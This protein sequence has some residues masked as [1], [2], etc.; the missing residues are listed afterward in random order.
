MFFGSLSP[1]P[2]GS[3][4]GLPVPPAHAGAAAAC[5]GRLGTGE[6]QTRGATPIKHC[7]LPAG[8]SLCRCTAAARCPILQRLHTF[9]GTPAAGRLQAAAGGACRGCRPRSIAAVNAA[10]AEAQAC[11][12]HMLP[13]SACE[14][15]LLPMNAFFYTHT[16]TPSFR[17]NES[18]HVNTSAPPRQQRAAHTSGQVAHS[19]AASKVDPGNPERH[20]QPL[21]V[22]ICRC[23][24]GNSSSI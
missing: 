15:A 23:G 4:G 24:G 7:L 16:H 6:Q 18:P 5:S 20:A 13:V 9:V 3:A 14:W 1:A 12:L 10:A 21:R 17:S 8:C 22:C 2:A 19:W 11:R